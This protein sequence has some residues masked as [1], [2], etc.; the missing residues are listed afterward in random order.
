ML[1]AVAYIAPVTAMAPHWSGETW[2][3]VLV[4][5]LYGAVM[6]AGVKRVTLVVDA[7]DA[8]S[9]RFRERETFVSGVLDS[10]SERVATFDAGGTTIGENVAWVR[11]AE[12][13]D[14]RR[15]QRAQIKE[16]LDGVLP[17]SAESYDKSCRVG[18]DER[19]FSVRATALP[20]DHGFMISYADV[21]RRQMAEQELRHRLTQQKAIASFA[22]EAP[23][24]GT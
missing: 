9:A 19:C 6:I 13:P 5:A 23:Q 2:V 16:V 8:A 24:T 15:W 17:T 4:A 22:R 1:G 7:R 3:G 14:L 12:H 21:T 18:E 20:A 11:D 10:L